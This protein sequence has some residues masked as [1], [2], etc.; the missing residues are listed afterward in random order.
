VMD[1]VT[2]PKNTKFGAVNIAGGKG[3]ECTGIRYT[4]VFQRKGICVGSK[5]HNY[6]L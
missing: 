6:C 4:P 5:S 3:A 1:M 2:T